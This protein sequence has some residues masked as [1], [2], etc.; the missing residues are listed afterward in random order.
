MDVRFSVLRS[1]RPFLPKKILGTDFFHMISHPQNR[2]AAGGDRSI[3]KSNELVGK[4]PPCS[5]ILQPVMPFS[6]FC[7]FQ[8][9][10]LFMI[11]Q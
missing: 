3:D 4:P 10:Y 7:F 6:Y 1:G 8:I 5:V 9:D 11:S 2:I